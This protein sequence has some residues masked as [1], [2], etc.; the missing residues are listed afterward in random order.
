[1]SDA[2]RRVS[3]LLRPL[4]RLSVRTFSTLRRFLNRAGDWIDA[5]PRLARW[6]Y[7]REDADLAAVRADSDKTR[8]DL[9]AK[10][11]PKAALQD[12]EAVL[13]IYPKFKPASEAAEKIRTAE[14]KK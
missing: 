6:V 3:P 12:Y 5:R 9:A 14:S 11:D 1:M 7:P 2:P 4:Q 13:K 10:K 8:A